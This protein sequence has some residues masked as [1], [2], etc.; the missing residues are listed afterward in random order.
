MAALVGC[1]GGGD[2]GGEGPPLL[3]GATTFF[4]DGDALYRSAPTSTVTTLVQNP[5]SGYATT[6]Y[7]LVEWSGSGL[8]YTQGYNTPTSGTLRSFDVTFRSGSPAR[9]TLIYSP[10]P[11]P[12]TETRTDNASSNG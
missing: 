4:I 1:G 2:G 12:S 5:T 8:G 3:P 10:P 9:E 7:V 11:L 6:A